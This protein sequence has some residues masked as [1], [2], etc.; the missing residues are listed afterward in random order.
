LGLNA[1]AKEVFDMHEKRGR[2][3]DAEKVS[4]SQD[5]GDEGDVLEE[6]FSFLTG[7]RIIFSDSLE[8]DHCRHDGIQSLPP[9]KLD[10]I[11]DSVA[12]PAMCSNASQRG[13]T[14]QM[15][16]SPETSTAQQTDSSGVQPP[17]VSA[18][19]SLPFSL[20]GDGDRASQMSAEEEHGIDETVK[21][22]QKGDVG[23]FER[24]K[25]DLGEEDLDLDLPVQRYIPAAT[26]FPTAHQTDKAAS[27]H[28]DEFSSIAGTKASI[29]P[30]SRQNDRDRA[31]SSSETRS[32][33][34]RE[35]HAREAPPTHNATVARVE[36]ADG[37]TNPPPGKKRWFVLR[38]ITKQEKEEKE[39]TENERLLKGIV[40]DY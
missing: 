34:S 35:G 9:N 21:E 7:E 32:V 5:V 29:A 13:A 18:I 19:E 17:S 39:R 27:S 33:S 20:L 26:A 25:G 12:V 23:P 11:P 16:K 28:D 37:D 3:E 36:A 14:S 30:L 10:S 24:D 2:M 1:G 38:K 15:S 8:E 22:R 4:T 40:F 31:V 6:S